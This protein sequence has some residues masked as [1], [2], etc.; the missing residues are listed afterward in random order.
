MEIVFRIRQEFLAGALSQQPGQQF[1][2]IEFRV[3]S[4]HGLPIG[5]AE[6]AKRRNV[7]CARDSGGQYC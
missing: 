7:V 2:S 3:G 5:E 4:G 6:S 1:T